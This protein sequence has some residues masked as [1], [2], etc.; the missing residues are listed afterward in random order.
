MKNPLK[1]I[2]G[3]G[4]KEFAKTTDDPEAI[5]SAMDAMPTMTEKEVKTEP[6]KSQLDDDKRHGKD[7]DDKRH[8]RD[9]DRRARMHGALDK[10]L[11]EY[12]EKEKA[13]DVDLG[14]LKD[15]LNQ[16]FTEEQ[17]E[18]EHEG[19]A[20]EGVV[21]GKENVGENKE[22][23]EAGAEAEQIDDEEEVKPVGEVKAAD[24]KKKGKDDDDDKRSAD[25]A[26]IV[27]PEPELSAKERPESQMDQAILRKAQLQVLKSLRP[28]AAR[29]KD[30]AFRNAFDTA[31]RQVREEGDGSGSHAALLEASQRSSASDQLSQMGVDDA[32]PMQKQA[33][34]FDDMYKNAMKARTEKAGVG[35]R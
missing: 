1:Y 15:L 5:A 28:F 23:S 6:P 22:Q 10:I 30:K 19:D 32:T 31:L 35:R 11:N 25:D 4:L 9:D 3:L 26:E 16:F 8:G 29:S 13:G 20:K 12:E 2:F 27:H 34:A 7:D 17:A 14:A 21:A 33:V 24:D 18:Q